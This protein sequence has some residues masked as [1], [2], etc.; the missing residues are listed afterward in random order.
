M[1]Q[2]L[3]QSVCD[4]AELHFRH[5]SFLKYSPLLHVSVN[6]FNVALTCIDVQPLKVETPSEE[7]QESL[8]LPFLH[9]HSVFED[10]LLRADLCTT[11]LSF[12]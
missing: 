12:L 7:P 10:I 2:A 4:S 5:V 8:R 1:T 6:Q 3:I 11:F 9:S